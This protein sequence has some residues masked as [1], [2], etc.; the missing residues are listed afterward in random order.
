MATTIGV[1]GLGYIGCV[2][3]AALGRA[4]FGVIGV[5]TNPQKVAMLNDGIATVLEP[6][7]AELVREQVRT[8]QL[9][10][11]VHAREAVEAASTYLVCVGSP[12][13]PNG[14]LDTM[15][16]ERACSQIGSALRGAPKPATIVIRST[17]LPGTTEDLLIPTI[18]RSSKLRV[19]EHIDV[20]FNPEFLR[21]GSAVADFER[22]PF[23]IIGAQTDGAARGVRRLYEHIDAPVKVTSVRVAEMLKYA[24][25][26]WRAVKVSF[27][28]EIGNTCRAFG[29]DSHEVMSLFCADE[30][31]NI[32]AAY[33]KPGFAF[34]GSCLP[35]DLRALVYRARQCDIDTPVLAAA[36]ASNRAQ[37]Q[38]AFDLVAATQK[39]R[40][41]VLGM[42]F[43]AG[44]DDLRE[45]PSVALIE[46]L[47]G[48]GYELHIYDADVRASRLIGANCAFIEREIPHLWSLV[49]ES[50]DAV[51][52]TSDVVVIANGASEFHTIA[53]R[54]RADQVV[55]DL[56]RAIVEPTAARVEGL[57]W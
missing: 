30:R 1:F 39:K 46:M 17:V 53:P 50:A 19:G 48:K 14:A 52:A 42:A 9:W 6:G 10:A 18:E 13:L 37:I 2:T 22:P 3:A 11:T 12:S 28:N 45:S 47:L 23:I 51:I 15:H 8:R 16:V 36:L 43:K 26:C 40:V 21:T 49:R 41:G 31:L 33:L 55:I 29:I 7:L 54:L 27:A 32:S 34:G 4:G 5:E 25:N 56:M 44:S 20:C 38:R 57:C 24:S 35:K